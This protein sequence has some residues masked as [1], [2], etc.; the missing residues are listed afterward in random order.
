MT[1][2]CVK[3]YSKLIVVRIDKILEKNFRGI[4]KNVFYNASFCDHCEVTSE[5]NES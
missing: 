5:A 2:V 4:S 3:F 1:S